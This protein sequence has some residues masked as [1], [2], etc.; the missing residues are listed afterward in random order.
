MKKQRREERPPTLTELLAAPLPKNTR[1]ILEFCAPVG[2]FADVDEKGGYHVLGQPGY[3]GHFQLGLLSGQ[4]WRPAYNH[5]AYSLESR[6]QRGG[7]LHYV[8]CS[9]SA[10]TQVVAFVQHHP[11]YKKGKLHDIDTVLVT[12]LWDG[13]EA[14]PYKA[15]RTYLAVLLLPCPCDIYQSLQQT[16]DYQR[17]H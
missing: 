13:S 16:F 15:K 4:K 11:T 2:L 5:R 3:P 14:A 1:R 12:P 17:G 7:V 8:H 6:Q 10:H 9:A